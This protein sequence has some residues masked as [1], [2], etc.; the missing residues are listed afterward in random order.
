VPFRF[1][2]RWDGL[3]SGL[4]P[5]SEAVA[6]RRAMGLA[7][8]DLTPSNPTTTGVPLPGDWM[9]LL[10]DPDGR[11]YA[12]D[13]KGL[14]AAREAIARYYG[15]RDGADEEQSEASSVNPDDLFLTAGTS[16]GYSHLFKLLCDPGDE[17]L[18]PRPSYPLLDTLAGL[19]GIELRGYPLVPDADSP[20]WRIDFEALEAALSPRVR[21]LVVVSPNNPT[22]NILSSG[23]ATSLLEFAE[24]HGL[25]VIV[26]EV[27]ADY[28]FEGTES[29]RR[30]VSN[31][32]PVF[33]LNGLSK[34]V[35]LP[36]LKLAWIHAAGNAA[37]KAKAKDALEWMC[38]AHLS[39][40]TAPQLAAPELLRRRAEFQQPI[41]ERLRE[42]LA[43]LREIAS[44]HPW[45]RPM[46]PQGGWCVPI[47]CPGIGDDEA[48]AIRLVE[49]DGV[50]VQPGYFYDF[51]DGDGDDE[52]TIVV[53]LLTPPE[54]FREGL[55]K[56]A[57]ALT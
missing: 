32:V 6:R 21:A 5:L 4:N 30:L 49:E 14:P 26:D 39:V 15:E 29:P 43:A 55:A 7:L 46:W 23:D 10:A 40:G 54:I 44:R 9:P 51:G 18:V 20:A 2:A 28:V 50:L 33:T 38:D 34:L 57:V 52:E 8:L 41:R 24:R 19:S 25:A 31:H 56:L 45:M 36:Q 13:P 1:P 53:S 3:E 37:D 12:P 47:R 16:E 11:V 27:F 17:I 22:G 35:G 42:N 48:F